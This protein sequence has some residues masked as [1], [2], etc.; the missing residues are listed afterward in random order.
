MADQPPRQTRPAGA[1][2]PPHNNWSPYVDY[3][4]K[5]FVHASHGL[6]RLAGAIRHARRKL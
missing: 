3:T 2:D 4:A 1:F 6:Y 5:A